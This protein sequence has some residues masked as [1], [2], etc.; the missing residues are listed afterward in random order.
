[1]KYIFAFLFIAFIPVSIHT[2]ENLVFKQYEGQKY[3]VLSQVEEKVYHNKNFLHEASILNKI[4]VAVVEDSEFAA[5]IQSDYIITEQMKNSNGVFKL[6]NEYRSTYWRNDLGY[7][8]IDKMYIFPTVRNVPVFSGIPVKPGDTWSAFGEELHKFPFEN[9]SIIVRFPIKAVYTY[10]GKAELEGK[11]FD[12]IR[13]NYTVDHRFTQKQISNG[14]PIAVQGQFKQ[15]VY[16]DNTKGN[17]A[18]TEEAFYLA[19][20]FNQSDLYEWNGTSTTRIIEARNMDKDQLKK[21]LE[22]QF[23]DEGIDDADIRIDKDGVSINLPD[24]VLHFRPDS[25][26][27]RPGEFEKLRKIAKVVKN[28]KNRDIL[29]TGHTARAGSEESSQLL[30]EQ[31]AAII[32]EYFL[33]NEITRTDQLIIRGMGS[34]QPVAPNTNEAN[35]KKNRRV[36]IK[37]LEN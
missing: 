19:I 20:L 16:W 17:F 1:M 32:A 10:A 28:Y 34:R 27:L 31:R 8:E 22:K 26:E 9:G 18:Y 2:Q 12:K 11:R 3:R 25:T 5:K 37:I 29:I 30:S 7:I 36:E 6:E 35:M 15:D 23:E 33:E 24:D 14:H 13:I 4:S 21:D